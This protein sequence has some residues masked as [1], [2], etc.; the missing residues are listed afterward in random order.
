MSSLKLIDNSWSYF[1]TG[2]SNLN[3]AV[4]HYNIPS[5]SYLRRD[6][7]KHGCHVN[8]VNG[9]EGNTCTQPDLQVAQF[10]MLFPHQMKMFLPPTIKAHYCIDIVR[11]LLFCISQ[12]EVVLFSLYAFSIQWL[13]LHSHCRPMYRFF[14]FVPFTLILNM[15]FKTPHILKGSSS[16]IIKDTGYGRWIWSESCLIQSI[17]HRKEER[18]TSEDH[19]VV[20]AFSQQHSQFNRSL[21]SSTLF[22]RMWSSPSL[23]W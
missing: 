13:L 7:G 17:H 6:V 9:A 8:I 18:K 12:T 5:A 22:L 11:R 20:V 3:T 19:H 21:I 2:F 15:L 4:W 16:T 14:Y 1:F 23:S 10:Q